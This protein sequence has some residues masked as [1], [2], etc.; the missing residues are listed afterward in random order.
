MR[1]QGNY[2]ERGERQSRIGVLV[3]NLGTPAAPTTTAVRRYLAEF[4]ADPRVV[5]WP[6][7]L[8]WPILHGIV[9]RVRPARAARAY[10][11]IWLNEGSPLAVGSERLLAAIAAEFEGIPAFSFALAMRYGEPSI[12]AGLDRLRRTGA[13][14]ILVLPLYP[15]YSAATSGSVFDG[16]GAALRRQRWVPE[17]HFITAYHLLSGYIDALAD[18]VRQC[19]TERDGARHLLLSFHG[20]PQSCI[21]QG[22]PYQRHCEA[23]ARALVARLGL[24][25]GQWELTYQSRFGP[26]RWLGPQ[27]EDRLNALPR[28][29]KRQVDV[30]C[31]GFAVDCLETLE[32]VALRGTEVLRD[33]GGEELRYIPALNDAPAHAKALAGLIRDRVAGWRVMETAALP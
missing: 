5:E 23:T 33:A 10:Q 19:K 32:E 18:S 22:D 15:Q 31:P 8:W 26:V 20:L 24:A 1:Y 12:E 21:A 2:L 11:R 28:E 29:G 9:L 27:L 4:L 30:L 7:W 16:V 6:R 14:R 3:V 17:V 13:D 25:D